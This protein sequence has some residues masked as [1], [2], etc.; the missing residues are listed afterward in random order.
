MSGD[1]TNEC[2]S[3]LWSGSSGWSILNEPADLLSVPFTAT[4]P[5]KKPANPAEELDSPKTPSFC[6]DVARYAKLG[7]EA[8]EV[9]EAK[10]D[11][12]RY[13]DQMRSIAAAGLTKGG[14][15]FHFASKADLAVEVVR[16]RDEQ[17]QHEVL[18]AAAE[19]ARASE[20]VVAMVRALVQAIALKSEQGM[21]GLERLCAELRADGV[22]DPA[23]VQPHER[24]VETTAAL[25]RQAQAEGDLEPG[26]DPVLA[27]RFAV[28]SFVG[29]E[30]TARGSASGD[31]LGID[32]V[33][34]G[35]DR[36]YA[37][38]RGHDLGAAAEAA[39]AETNPL[40]LITPTTTADDH[41]NQSRRS[42]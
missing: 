34:R 19:H 23:V 13:A 8:I 16:S 14:F 39:I 20:Q 38:P 29:L 36:P 33:C 30:E 42:A 41:H 21:A 7:V 37:E 25:F 15:Y 26:T 12:D 22:D 3:H 40:R 24:W 5:L 35:S 18:A 17:L 11:D 2:E 1:S 31:V 32:V 9:V 4:L 10:L 28:S 27:A 6:E